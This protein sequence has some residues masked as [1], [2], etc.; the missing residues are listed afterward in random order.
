MLVHFAEAA[1]EAGPGVPGGCHD[2][3]ALEEAR[4]KLLAALGSEALVE[5]AATVAN[6]QRMDRIADGTGIALDGALDLM[7]ADM[8]Q[9]LGIDAYAAAANTRRASALKR[10]LSGL[11]RP[12][13]A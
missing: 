11:L 7:T 1:V 9:E 10:R 4:Q 13:T 3:P 5:A 12:A 8:R 2:D 6:F